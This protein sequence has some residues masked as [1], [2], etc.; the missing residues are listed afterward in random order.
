MIVVN[1]AKAEAATFDRLRTERA[2]MLESLDVAYMRALEKGESADAIV[3]EKQK[4]RDVTG[5]D[6]STLSIEDM[7]SLTLAEAMELP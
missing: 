4:L 7:A 2:P 1:R 3:L 5:K 6:L